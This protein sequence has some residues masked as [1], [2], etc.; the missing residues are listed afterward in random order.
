MTTHRAHTKPVLIV[1]PPM[2]EQYIP[3]VT[4]T[5][6]PVDAHAPLNKT[7]TLT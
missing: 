4:H 6:S 3:V 5:A 7:E 2:P 1:G